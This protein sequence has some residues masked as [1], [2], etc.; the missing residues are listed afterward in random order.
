MDLEKLKFVT[1]NY[2][3]NHILFAVIVQFT[4][5]HILMNQTETKT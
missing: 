1:S 4:T 5:M 2:K 3:N